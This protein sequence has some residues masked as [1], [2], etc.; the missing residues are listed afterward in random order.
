MELLKAGTTA[1]ALDFLEHHPG[2]RILAG[3]TDLIISL[4]KRKET[5]S[6]IVDI[7]QVEEL[8]VIRSTDRG[9]QIGPCTTYAQLVHAA[10]PRGLGGLQSAARQV[11]SPQI[12]NTATVG[13]NICNSS[14]AADIVPPLM[15]LDA[16][17]TLAVR[18]NG[19]VSERTLPLTE[20][21]TGKGKNRLLPGELLVN[22]TLPPVTEDAMLVFE[23]LGLREA[24]AISRICLALYAEQT[25]GV[26]QNFRVATG[27]LGETGLRE[28]EVEEYLNESGLSDERIAGAQEILS[29][30]CARRLAARSTM[31]FK[32]EAIKGL[33]G[34]ALRSITA[35]GNQNE[36]HR[37]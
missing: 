26:W 13:G 22:V 24:L 30:T 19:A 21:F 1:E 18:K 3:G 11:G 14:P 28:A 34:H 20:F 5:P 15:A 6:A 17:L 8:K 2:A 10:L 35:G 37:Q 12:R 16:Q 32:R 4:R 7:S 31:P 25:G 9:W 33:L 36:S 27:S 29:Q 23:K